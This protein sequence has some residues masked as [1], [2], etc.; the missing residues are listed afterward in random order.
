MTKKSTIKHLAL[1]L[2]AILVL[3]SCAGG[4]IVFSSN[5]SAVEDVDPAREGPNPSAQKLERI[6]SRWRRLLPICF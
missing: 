3:S 4:E 2:S 5:T 1:L 6:R